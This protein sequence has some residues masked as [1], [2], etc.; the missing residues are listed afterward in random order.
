MAANEYHLES[1][2]RAEGTVSEVYDVIA[3]D[4]ALVDWWPS[5][6]LRCDLV[7]PGQPGGVGKT[8]RVVTK[9]W[10]PYTINWHQRVTASREPNGFSIETWGDFA[11]RGVWTFTQ[12]RAWVDIHFDWWIAVDKP[13]LRVLSP[14]VKPIFTFNHRWAM[15]RGEE[16]LHVEL[17]RRRATTPEARAAI[18]PPPGPTWPHRRRGQSVTPLAEA[19]R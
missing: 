17:R 13:L 8:L 5:A 16:S 1:T 14:L 18:P 4:R 3:D 11:G 2:W 10:L 7:D 15:A 9:G 19:T 6:F 12:N